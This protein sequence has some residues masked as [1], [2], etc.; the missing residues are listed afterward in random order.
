MF[1]FVRHGETDYEN[2]NTLI[3]QGFGANL[4][5]LTNEGIEQIK[6]TSKDK[7]LKDSCIILSSPYTRA[8][9]TAAILSKELGVDIIVETNLHEWLANK[10]YTYEEDSIAD[11]CY[12]EYTENKGVYPNGC[13]RNWEDKDI[14]KARVIEVL[15]RYKHYSKVIIAAHGMMIHATTGKKGIKNG[16]IVEFEL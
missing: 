5:P 15:E 3:Y 6:A 13:E 10:N 9:Q 14:M 12:Q 7:R 4:A 8:L 1:Y 11:N 16:E 2:R